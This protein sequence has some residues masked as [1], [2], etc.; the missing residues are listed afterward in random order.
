MT[1]AVIRGVSH[2]K[3]VKRADCS[4]WIWNKSKMRKADKG[5]PMSFDTEPHVT[6]DFNFMGENERG[7]CSCALGS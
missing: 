7:N 6:L 1:V 5:R 3:A 4:C 2:A